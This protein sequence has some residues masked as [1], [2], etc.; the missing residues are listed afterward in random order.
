MA[1]TLDYM[2]GNIA[3][4]I[5]FQEVANAKWLSRSLVSLYYEIIASAITW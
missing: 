4:N 1:C 2:I 5:S 3:I